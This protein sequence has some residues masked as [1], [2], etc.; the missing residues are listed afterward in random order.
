MALQALPRVREALGDEGTEELLHWLDRRIEERAVPRD[1]YRLW[2]TGREVLSRL[3][4]LEEDVSLLRDELTQTRMEFRED[5][6]Q[7]RLEMNE[8]FDRMNERFDQMYDRM[9]LQT[10]WLIG[11]LALI[12]TVISALLA[13]GQFVR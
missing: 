9:L 12:G 8:R 4:L 5:M 11:S 3:D 2:A 1:E 6:G 7:L 10:R 13:I